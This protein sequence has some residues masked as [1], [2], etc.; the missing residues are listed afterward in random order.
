MTLR[1]V[2]L[3]WQNFHEIL[4]LILI[5]HFSCWIGK[6]TTWTPL[7]TYAMQKGFSHPFVFPIGVTLEF[8]VDVFIHLQ[9]SIQSSYD[10]GFTY[11]FGAI[12]HATLISSCIWL[13]TPKCKWNINIPNRLLDTEF[14]LHC[15]KI[16]L[17]LR[18]CC[19]EE[20]Q[21]HCTDLCVSTVITVM[22]SMKR[23]E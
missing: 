6:S 20:N 4:R 12:I 14:S 7:A 8:N 2:V 22:D 11:F 19:S 13:V 5:F 16:K 18:D 10:L 3:I 9:D 15:R 17:Y 23:Q 21:V 1:K